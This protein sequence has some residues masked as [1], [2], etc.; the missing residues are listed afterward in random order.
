M[1]M[2]E[3]EEKKKKKQKIV[4][5]R[6]S[7]TENDGKLQYACNADVDASDVMRCGSDAEQTRR[8]RGGEVVNQ[9]PA[10]DVAAW[11]AGAAGVGV[12][13]SE[14]SDDAV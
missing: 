4:D 8:E 7:R 1:E 9:K 5:G 6:R 13:E 10:P 2:A 11:C 3:K 12:S 14:R